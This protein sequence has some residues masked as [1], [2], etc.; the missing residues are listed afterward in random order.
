MIEPSRSIHEPFAVDGDP[1][2]RGFLHRA[3]DGANRAAASANAIVLTH[4]A[5]SNAQIPLLSALADAFVARGL[6]V[7][8]CD[9]PFRQAR[10]S[11]PPSPSGAERDRRGLAAAVAAMKTLG[12][13]RCF[14]GGHSYGGRQAS[15]LLAESPELAS[16]LLLLSYPLHP[17]AAP[18]RLRTQHLSSLHVPTL[19]VHGDRD[20]FG[21]PD[22]IEAAR[23]VIPATSASLIVSRAAHALRADTSTT[24]AIVDAFLRLVG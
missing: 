6:V 20:P 12:A 10:R 13:R 21:T 16:G 22:E 3:A 1:A 2:V 9:L 11:G 24:R 19:F 14:L 17:P 4:G 5:G 7:L 8:R 23:G 18:L 15:M